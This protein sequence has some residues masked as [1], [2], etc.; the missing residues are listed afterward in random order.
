MSCA[1]HEHYLKHG[2]FRIEINWYDLTLH[3]FKDNIKKFEAP[4]ASKKELRHQ[5]SHTFG[6][7]SCGMSKIIIFVSHTSFIH[8]L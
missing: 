1:N 4:K 3:H 6:G 8:F 5:N 7:M 2:V